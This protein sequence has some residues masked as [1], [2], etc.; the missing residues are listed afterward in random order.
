MSH[1]STLSCDQS[2]PD[3][4]SQEGMWHS[5]VTE[6]EKSRLESRVT[7]LEQELRDKEDH[8]QQQV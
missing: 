6:G 7:A 4:S 8:H 5:P 3:D 1:G 2:V